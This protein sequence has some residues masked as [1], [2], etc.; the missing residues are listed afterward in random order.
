MIPLLG[1]TEYRSGKKKLEEALENDET[2]SQL[3]YVWQ[4][5]RATSSAPSY[6]KPHGT[7][8]DGGIYANNPTSKALSEIALLELINR[9]PETSA[10]ATNFA[11]Q[12]KRARIN[13]GSTL[14]SSATTLANVN[15]LWP[16]YSHTDLV[17]SVG[18]GSN[19]S[20]RVGKKVASCIQNVGSP[21]DFARLLLNATGVKALFE[22]LVARATERDGSDVT[23]A[24]AWCLSKGAAY[25][26]LTPPL[27]DKLELDAVDTRALIRALCDTE[28]Y[29][30]RNKELIH[31]I[32]NLLKN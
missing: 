31:E 14:Q 15:E 6:F 18:C 29:L 16:K 32:C 26:R 25:V 3:E 21:S 24:S 30:Y 8:I 10:A 12:P 9:E 5:A 2:D 1:E 7:Y 11:H 20:E 22:L 19:A 13:L 23:E 27:A 17:L 28:C 4:V